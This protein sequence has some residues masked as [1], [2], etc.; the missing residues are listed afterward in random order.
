MDCP[1]CGKVGRLYANTETGEDSFGKEKPAGRWICFSCGKKSQW[2]AVLMSELEGIP[3]HEARAIIGK[4]KLS[5]IKFKRHHR[6]APEPVAPKD[7]ALDW[8]PAEFE[9]VKDV[10]PKYLTRRGIS[11]EV[12]IQLNLGVCRRHDKCDECKPGG[13]CPRNMAHRI[14]LPIEC[15]LGRDFQARA[16]SA[17]LEPRYLSGPNSGLLLFGWNTIA[18]TNIAVL[19]EGPFDAIKVIQAGLP[20]VAM[21]GKQLRD[22]QYEM[23]RKKRRSYVVMLDPINKDAQAIDNAVEI[24]ERLGGMVGVE[25]ATDPGDAEEHDIMSAYHSAMSPR[26]ARSYAQ[27]I[28]NRHLGGV[29]KKAPIDL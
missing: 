29:G 19:V 25:L 5:G 26:D 6:K 8:L 7:S 22:S 24:A 20:S 13:G 23:L 15:P 28:R 3:H 18:D 2:L 9:S 14:I 17:D 4:W 12:A 10:W 11:K 21:M 27:T 16:I 1:F